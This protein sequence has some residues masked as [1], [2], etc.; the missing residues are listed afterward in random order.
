[1]NKKNYKK[2]FHKGLR[3]PPLNILHATTNQKYTGMTEE[4]WDRLHDRARTLG[5][6]D[7]NDKPLA[8]GN[9][10]NDNKYDKDSNFPDD[11]DEYAIS[12]DGVDEPL[13]EG[14]NEYDSLSAAP[15]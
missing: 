13:E 9:D 15:V 6:P 14:N 3:W 1:M 2:K 11:N 12:V 7:G 4:G 10:D 5:E 8:E